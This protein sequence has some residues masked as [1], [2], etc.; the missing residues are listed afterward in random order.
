MV[1]F[2]NTVTVNFTVDKCGL[3]HVEGIEIIVTEVFELYSPY[4]GCPCTQLTSKRWRVLS[5][6]L[7]AGIEVK[8]K[9]QCK[10]L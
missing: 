1:H 10:Y 5:P 9:D 7:S 2:T 6:S 4:I 8:L 3:S